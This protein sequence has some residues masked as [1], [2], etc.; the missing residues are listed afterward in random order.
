MNRDILQGQ[1]K[2]IRGKV[3]QAWGDLTDDD[4]DRIDGRR[5]EL[6]GMLQRK[7][8]YTKE[9]AAREVDDFIR[10]L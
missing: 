5:T 3:Q 10:N 8:G 1:W 4:L 9:R 7:Y 6:E 2:E